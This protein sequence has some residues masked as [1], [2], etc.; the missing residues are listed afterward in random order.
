[1]YTMLIRGDVVDVW[2]FGLGKNGPLRYVDSSYAWV[3]PGGAF[4]LRVDGYPIIIAKA[5]PRMIVG[6]DENADVVD[7][8]VRAFQR[9]G[10]PTDEIYMCILETPDLESAFFKR[11]RETGLQYVWTTN[12]FEF[13]SGCAREYIAIRRRDY[14][15]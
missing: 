12:P 5:G 11:A 4:V 9:H 14:C 2:T 13:E 6:Y 8:I 15:H 10:T 1:M 3:K 7:E